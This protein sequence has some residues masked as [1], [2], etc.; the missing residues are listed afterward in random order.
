MG[1][2]FWT[3]KVHLIGYVS[4][5]PLGVIGCPSRGRG[6]STAGHTLVLQKWSTCGARPTHDYI[7]SHRVSRTG[8]LR[9]QGQ[10]FPGRVLQTLLY[11]VSHTRRYY[12]AHCL[13]VSSLRLLYDVRSPSP[14]SV[15]RPRPPRHHLL[16]VKVG[17]LKIIG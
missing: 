15:R 12:V 11:S 10:P 3:I 2:S 4:T 13:V 7:C 6:S 17:H 8:G 1:G 16:Q 9:G 14:F 5:I